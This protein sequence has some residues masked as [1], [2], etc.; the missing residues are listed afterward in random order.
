MQTNFKKKH[1]KKAKRITN[2]TIAIVTTMK[3]ISN[4][5]YIFTEE[6]FRLLIKRE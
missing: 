5:K 4:K 6:H 1:T 2:M 3:E